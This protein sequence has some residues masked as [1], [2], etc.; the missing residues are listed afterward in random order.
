MKKITQKDLDAAFQSGVSAGVKSALEFVLDGPV[1]VLRDPEKKET[2]VKLPDGKVI[3]VRLG[4]DA[5]H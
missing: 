1:E 3:G 5:R 2:L 4:L